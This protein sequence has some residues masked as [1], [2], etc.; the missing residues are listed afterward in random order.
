MRPAGIVRFPCRAADFYRPAVRRGR[1]R[2]NYRTARDA[3][4]TKDAATRPR[5][6]LSPFT[7]FGRGDWLT[8]AAKPL[9]F[10]LVSR[11]RGRPPRKSEEQPQA[12]G[13]RLE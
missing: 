9:G 4:G 7:S 2:R 6:R 13:Q 11:R 10:E 3:T 5:P 12:K 1:D 8:R